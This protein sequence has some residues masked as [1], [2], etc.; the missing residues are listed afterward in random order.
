MSTYKLV[1]IKILMIWLLEV[2]ETNT[3][4]ESV[5]SRQIP[6]CNKTFAVKSNT[7]IRSKDSQENGAVFIQEIEEI[8]LADC[9]RFCCST[10]FCDVS[11]Y[12]A[13]TSCYLFACD[14]VN[15]QKCQFSPHEDF[16]TA[17]VSS[18]RR[19]GDRRVTGGDTA[20][21]NQQHQLNNITNRI[22]RPD[23]RRIEECGRWEFSCG[24]GECIPI[25]DTCNGIDQCKDG[26]DE[27]V[28]YCGPPSTT[29]KYTT[30]EIRQKNAAD[31]INQSGQV[32]KEP[33]AKT[34]YPTWYKNIGGSSNSSQKSNIKSDRQSRYTQSDTQYK[35]LNDE[36]TVI[37]EIGDKIGQPRHSFLFSL[38]F[39]LM[40]TLLSLG[41]FTGYKS[42]RTR[43]YIYRR[44]DLNGDENDFYN[45]LSL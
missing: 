38:M 25:Y 35:L 10:P 23:V 41:L 43:G 21:I 5:N 8:S 26:S 9:I 36:N 31:N 20:Q 15:T 40:L 7:I 42:L 29:I 28:E 19:S 11:V 34:S 37:E 2:E 12:G 17:V 39:L 32:M 22:Q 1:T 18:E 16:E 27:D 30:T 44:L 4:Q 24:S 6:G 33:K 13:D 45:G 14:I 3:Q